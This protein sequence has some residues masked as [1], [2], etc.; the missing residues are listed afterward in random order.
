MLAF[1]ILGGALSLYIIWGLIDAPLHVFIRGH[2]IVYDNEFTSSI[3]VG[4]AYVIATCGAL[5]F[6]GYRYLVVFG[7]LNMIGLIAVLMIYA[8][9]FTSLWCAYAAVMSVI[10][11]FFFRQSRSKRPAT[12]A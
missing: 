10:I 7:I 1:V 12:F 6:S 4:S 8:Y 2:T 5:L 9:A 3:P 11:Y